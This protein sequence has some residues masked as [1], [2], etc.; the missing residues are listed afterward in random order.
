MSLIFSRQCEYAVQAVL[1]LALKPKGS[2]TSIK[3]LAR[4]LD[5]PYHFLGKILQSL[6]HKGLL[7]SQRGPSGGFALGMPPQDVTLFHIVEAIDGTDFIR[8]CVF[9]FSECSSKN[10]CSAHDQWSKLRDGVY[11]ML[12][13]KN[14]AAM[15]QDT[16]QP[17]FHRDAAQAGPFS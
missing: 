4:A 15:A 8:M 5:I 12:I 6:T 14:I 13:S 10:P 9:G 3:E 1:Y 2:M 16:K 7:L 17:A 11:Q